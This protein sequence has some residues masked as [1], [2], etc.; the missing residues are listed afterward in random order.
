MRPRSAVP[1]PRSSPA[2][3][4][5]SP[6]DWQTA[7]S[8]LGGPV[9][10]LTDAWGEVAAAAGC[11]FALPDAGCGTLGC[12]SHLAGR[13]DRR[14]PTGG[15]RM[16]GRNLA[17]IKVGGSLLDWPEL[18]GRLICLSRTRG[19][20]Q[21]KVNDAVLIAGGGRGRLDSQPRSD[22][23]PG[24]RGRRQTGRARARFDGRHPG[25]IAAGF[26]HDRSARDARARL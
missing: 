16:T 13:T 7:L 21:T 1:L 18:P 9:I 23:R 25:C 17:V 20:S 12:R 19:I 10:S 4:V 15:S 2:R 6:G 11:A 26:Y 22:S 5:S 8:T 24:Q 14:Q 3:G